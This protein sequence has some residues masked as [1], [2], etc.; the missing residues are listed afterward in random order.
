MFS[1]SRADPRLQGLERFKIL[2]ACHCPAW[3]FI[4]FLSYEVFDIIGEIHKMNK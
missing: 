1:S 4:G 3:L 2:I